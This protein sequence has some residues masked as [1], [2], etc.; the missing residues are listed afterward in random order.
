[1]LLNFKSKKE[2]IELFKRKIDDLNAKL[3]SKEHAF[4]I[5]LNDLHKELIATIEQ[6]DVVNEQHDLIGEMLAKILLEFNRVEANTIESNQ[7]SE[8]VLENGISL[9]N[10]SDKMVTVS[11][12]S[13]EAVIA[14]EN[15]ID[16]IGEQSR[17][18]SHNMNELSELSKQIENIVNVISDISKQ[19][20]LLAL[21]ASIEASRAGEDGRGFAVVADE[22]RKLAEST[23]ISTENIA[24]LTKRTQEQISKV[25]NDTNNSMLLAEQGMTTSVETSEQMNVLL[26]LIENVQGEVKKLLDD[27]DQQ[28]SSSEDVLLNFRKTSELFSEAN[29]IINS[30]IDDA[31]IVTKQLL[32]AV[33]LVKSF[34]TNQ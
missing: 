19:T 1:M 10:A 30:H 25:E 24:D 26:Q 33:N 31:D 5:F 29:D 13:K 23:K 9:I 34:P 14:V 12:N 32:K 21:N 2:D 7:I 18:T 6:H 16:N 28:K 22:V 27:I 17:T 3:D 8:Q 11:Q 20:N 4:Q 15:I